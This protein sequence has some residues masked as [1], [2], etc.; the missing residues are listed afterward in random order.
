MQLVKD[1]VRSARRLYEEEESIP[2]KEIVKRKWRELVVEKEED[3]TEKVNRLNY[4]M[5]VCKR[6][7]KKCARRRYGW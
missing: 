1:Y 6:C 3:G 4:E 2:I 5:C 7:G